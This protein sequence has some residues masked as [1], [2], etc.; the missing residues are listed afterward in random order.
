MHKNDVLQ[1]FQTEQMKHSYNR[2]KT[3]IH[4]NLIYPVLHLYLKMQDIFDL[5]RNL[6]RK[7]AYNVSILSMTH[8]K[9]SDSFHF[10]F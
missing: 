4:N 10:M 3:N 6:H 2:P 8:K 7:Y 9:P 5:I 1:S